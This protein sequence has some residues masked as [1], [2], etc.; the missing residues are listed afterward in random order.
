MLQKT[1]RK[2][3]QIF[4]KKSSK[5]AEINPANFAAISA[6]LKLKWAYTG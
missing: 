5:I 1:G 2:N 4:R 3:P 6:K